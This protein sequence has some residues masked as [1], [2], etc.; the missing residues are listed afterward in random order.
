MNNILD[1]INS[2]NRH[3][4]FLSDHE[5]MNMIKTRQ[6]GGGGETNAE[7][8]AAEQSSIDEAQE[9]ARKNGITDDT[10]KSI[11]QPQVQPTQIVPSVVPPQ[12]QAPPSLTVTQ[13]VEPILGDTMNK[14]EPALP[15]GEDN[16]MYSIPVGT[17]L[18]HGSLYKETFNP[19]HIRLGDERLIAYF[20]PNK[21]FAADRILACANY[22][23][24][25]GYIHKF[26]VTTAITDIKILSIYDRQ[27][28]ITLEELDD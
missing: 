9:I 17:I 1:L 6:Y 4:K 14:E 7:V 19:A 22:P 26:K 8:Q 16:T 13:T 25:S 15:Y 2:S 12:Q 24:R 11:P 27:I 23:S 20:S 3:G 10:G 5:I 21:S 18:Y 28:A